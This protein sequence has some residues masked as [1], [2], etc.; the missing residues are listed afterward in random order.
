MTEELARYSAVPPIM[1]FPWLKAPDGHP[2][3]HRCHGAVPPI[4][5][6]PWLKEVGATVVSLHRVGRYRPSWFFH[7]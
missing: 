4:M 1:V 2:P 3:V 7:G 5:V 6:F